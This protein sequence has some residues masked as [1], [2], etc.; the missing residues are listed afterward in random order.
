MLRFFGV[1]CV[2]GLLGACTT[3]T[4]PTSAPAVQSGPAVSRNVAAQNF[5]SVVARMEPIAEAECRARTRA[6]CDF[7]IAVHPDANAPRNAFQTLDRNGR[8]YIVFTQALIFDAR[9]R[10]EIAFIL[11][12]E[13]AH[14]I[15]G[16]IAKSNA[17]A[18]A[19]A[20]IL[21]AIIAAAGGPSYSVDAAAQLG[22]FVGS[23]TYSKEFELEA[24][25]LGTVIAAR[26]GYD[27]VKG[28]QYFNR[29]SDPGNQFLGTHPPNQ[30]RIATVQKVA[31]QL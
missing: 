24:D 25:A 11:G 4:A 12:H 9:N 13:A 22:G 6:N 28:A 1:I 7:Q 30:Q 16:H 17:N 8:P 21:G 19:G 10:D 15:E 29:V 14:H 27:P 5:Q 3:T 26:A 23:R 2:L 20:M 18:Q 31:S